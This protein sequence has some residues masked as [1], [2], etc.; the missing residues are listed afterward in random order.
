M[1]RLTTIPLKVMSDQVNYILKFFILNRILS[2]VVF[3]ESDFSTAGIFR[4]LLTQKP[5][6]YHII[7][8]IK[9]S[10]VT[11]R[12]GVNFLPPPLDHDNPIHNVYQI[13]GFVRV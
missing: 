5:D 6:I 11:L 2:T 4:T 1:A 8:Q 7:V 9:D 12:R 10:T 3:Q 13:M